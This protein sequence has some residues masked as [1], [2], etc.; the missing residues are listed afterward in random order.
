MGN[1]AP[2]TS[3]KSAHINRKALPDFMGLFIAPAATR[4]REAHRL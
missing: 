2:A 4:L 3:A 1:S